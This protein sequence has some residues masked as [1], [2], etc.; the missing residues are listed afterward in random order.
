[1]VVEYATD[2]GVV[3]AVSGVSFD[4]LPGETL[5]IVG[6][7]GC[8]KSTTGRAVLRLDRAIRGTIEFDGERI[9]QA[10]P[11]RMRALRRDMQMVFQDPVASLKPTPQGEGRRRGGPRDRGL[12]VAERSARAATVLAQVGL[13]EGRFAELMPRQLS[14]GR[15][16]AGGHSR[17][18][19]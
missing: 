16:A 1:L 6:E 14:G 9:D 12:P 15:G 8:G 7:S 17:A 19:R 11:Q 13:D 10:R 4:V 18:S 2:A 5:G 3:Q